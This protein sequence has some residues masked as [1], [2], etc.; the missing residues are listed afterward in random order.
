M[1]P[2]GDPPTGKFACPAGKKGTRNG[3][4]KRKRVRI[5]EGK[6][7]KKRKRGKKRGKEREKGK[8]E[9]ERG[10]VYQKMGSDGEN[11]L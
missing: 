1:P 7:K 4:E 9:R 3:A 2:F 6:G 11:R 5:I 10:K 8:R